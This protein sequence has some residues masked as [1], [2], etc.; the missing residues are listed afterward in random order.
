[1]SAT[2]LY[3]NCTIWDFWF[4]HRSSTLSKFN[5]FNRSL[6]MDSNIKSLANKL[7][8]LLWAQLNIRFIALKL[9]SMV[10]V[11]TGKVFDIAITLDKFSSAI[12]AHFKA[13][14]QSYNY[15]EQHT[16]SPHV[17]SWSF[18]YYDNFFSISLLLPYC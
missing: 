3:L 2:S 16:K 11:P 8:K 14:M 13:K 6:F 10:A 5:L 7:S 4:T 17:S 9:L 15:P 1:M 12:L 18:F